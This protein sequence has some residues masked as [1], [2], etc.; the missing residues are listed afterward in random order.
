MGSRPEIIVYRGAIECVDPEE[1]GRPDGAAA[2][3]TDDIGNLVAV[4]CVP[5]GEVQIRTATTE[6]LRN[7][8]RR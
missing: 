7:R 8:W 6:E 3:I 4:I 1:G 2:V 5:M